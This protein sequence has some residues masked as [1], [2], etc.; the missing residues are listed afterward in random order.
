MTERPIIFTAE[1]VE[2]ILAG[3]KTQTR[4]IIRQLAA[5]P[6]GWRVARTESRE[7]GDEQ[8]IRCP[9]KPGDVLWAKEAWYKFHCDNV[10][11]GKKYAYQ[12]VKQD[13]YSREI[14]RGDGYRWRSPLFMPREAARLFLKLIAVRAERVQDIS[15]A[16]CDAEG[17]PPRTEAMCLVT[18][19]RNRR[20]WYEKLWDSLNAKR[21]YPWSSN[22]WV[23][24]LTFEVKK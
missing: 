15:A 19:D 5:C 16:D 6:E 24:V 13:E 17:Y 23:W 7:N 10:I 2:A 21:G 9:Y 3:R 12:P 14:M 18:M 20:A 4:R 22:P 1:S 8:P 11:D